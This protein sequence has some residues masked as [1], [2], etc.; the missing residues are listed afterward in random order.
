MAFNG[1]SLNL[2]KVASDSTNSVRQSLEIARTRLLVSV[3]CLVLGFIVISLRLIEIGAFHRDSE[4]SLAQNEGYLG[5]HMGRESLVDRNGEILATSISTS[6]LYANATLIQNHK[7]VA[8]KLKKVFPQIDTKQLEEKLLSGKS[9][10]WIARH[11]TPHQQATVIRLGIPGL[12]FIRDTKRV[13]PYG[14]LLSHAVGFVDVDNNGISGLE[15]GLDEQL[16]NA[17]APIVLSLDIRLQHALYDELMNGIEEFSAQGASGMVLDTT[18]GEVLAMVS[19]P[20]FDPNKPDIKNSQT[21]FNRNT[22]GVYE[23]G[24]TMKIINT[25]MALE[26]ETVSLDSRFDATKPLKVGRFLVTDYHG[27]N[28]WMDVRDIFLYSSNIGAARMA[29]KAGSEKQ[30]AFMDKIGFLTAPQSE[31]PEM[32]SPLSPSKWREANTITISYGYGLAISPW[33]L[34]MAIAGIANEG[35]MPAKPTILKKALTQVEYK[36]IVKKSVS[37]QMVRLMQEAVSE[38]KCKK[39]AVPGILVGGKTG[40]ANRRKAHGRGYQTKDVNTTFI[41]IFPENPRYLVFVMLDD[42]K[43]TRSTYGFNAG[44]WNAAPVTSRVI[45]RIAPILGIYPSLDQD[46]FDKAPLI[47]EIAMR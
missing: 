22:L 10:L 15:K 8:A 17:T 12:E 42:P 34:S 16:R 30:R 47:R 32:G 3:V 14:A 31:L 5:L 19:L 41:G 46:K 25:A 11:L 33:Q 6:S 24:S 35:L 4:L 36:R 44:G 26:T 18:S 20:D 29:L 28:A 9:F 45:K 23:M 38:G 13:Y 21:L 27:K 2:F 7:E 37:L 39:A 40:T 1:K 43:A